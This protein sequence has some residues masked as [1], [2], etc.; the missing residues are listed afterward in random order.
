MNLFITGTDTDAGKTT[1]SAWICSHIRTKYWKIIQ[2]GND[3]DSSIIKQYS[4]N[5]E[6]IPEIYKLKA[7][8]SAYDA[9]KLENV[10]LDTS[11]FNINKDKVV[12]EGAGG[13]FVPIASNYLMIDAI[14][15]T[16]SKAL[17]I[18]RSKL[19]MINHILLTVFALREKEIP[20]VGIVISGD[21]NDNIKQTI[22]KFSKIK[23]LSV[24][25]ESNN[26]VEIFN[27]TSIPQEIM[28]VLL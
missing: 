6:I 23:I 5:T 22:E 9:A 16:N 17:I 11:K 12:I 15:S 7:P 26:L 3:S 27:K 14:K 19:G 10:V 25:P 28:E 4:P 8:L 2:T 1:V 21:I 20:I 24:L 13:V 18:S